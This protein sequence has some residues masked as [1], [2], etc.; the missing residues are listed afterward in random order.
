[1]VPRGVFFRLAWETRGWTEEQ[2]ALLGT[3]PEEEVARAVGRTASAVRVQR[4]LRGIPL[5]C[6]R[7]R[8]G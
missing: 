2:L 6:D 5:A 4:T 1:M 7:R 8:E 3:A